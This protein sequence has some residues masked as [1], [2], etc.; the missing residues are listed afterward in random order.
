MDEINS[1]LDNIESQLGKK[2]YSTVLNGNINHNFNNLNIPLRNKSNLYLENL[3][4]GTLNNNNYYIFNKNHDYNNY[5]NNFKEKSNINQLEKTSNGGKEYVINMPYS[6]KVETNKLIK[7]EI[8]PFSKNMCNEIEESLNNA[9][10][11]INILKNK[12]NDLD[13]LKD[14]LYSINKKLL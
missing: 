7:T 2:K 8:E 9:K 1:M 12:E 4:Y 11:E 10:T 6:Q 13:K 5:N 3:D 14:E